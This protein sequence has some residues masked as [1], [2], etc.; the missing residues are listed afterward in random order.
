MR[1]ECHFLQYS[2]LHSEMTLSEQTVRPTTN[3]SMLRFA[4]QEIPY[5]PMIP[6]QK[7]PMI[8]AS[9]KNTCGSISNRRCNTIR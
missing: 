6:V 4:Y 5:S 1:V 9:L 8:D 2:T 3:D 7:W